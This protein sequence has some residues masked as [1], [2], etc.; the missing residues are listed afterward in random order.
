MLEPYEIKALEHNLKDYNA[1]ATHAVK[2]GIYPDNET[3]L[4]YKAAR[5]AQRMIT[6]YESL[7]S[8]FAANLSSEDKV[9][10]CNNAVGY[11]NR[12]Q[13]ESVMAES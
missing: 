6:E 13:K 4:H 1:W 5:C 3:A 7:N 9:N 2:E 11:K 8:K 12:N 10:A